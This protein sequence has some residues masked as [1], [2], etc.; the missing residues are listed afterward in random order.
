MI[1]AIND[2]HV[3]E[4]PG[5]EEFTILQES[6]ISRAQKW[7]LSR[8]RQIGMEGAFRVL[9]LVPI[10][11][12]NARARYPDLAHFI[13]RTPGQGFGMDD[14]NL[15][16]TQV[17]TTTYQHPCANILSWSSD[18]PITLKCSTLDGENNRWSSLQATGDDQRR[19]CKPVTGVKS[20][21][22]EAAGSKG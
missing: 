8:I 13:R 9:W 21:P 7:A 19:L 1:I 12:R 3:F 22:A 6:Q 15:L 4:S 2:N 5:D 20:F 10:A 11:L 16:T 18:H 14:N 17:L